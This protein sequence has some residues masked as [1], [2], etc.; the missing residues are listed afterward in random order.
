V[1]DYRQR[2][3]R[4]PA[5]ARVA[6]LCAELAT[7]LA[8]LAAT[9]PSEAAPVE[10]LLTVAEA[11]ELLRISRT[12]AYQVIRTGELASVRIRGRR[13]IPTSAVGALVTARVS[14]GGSF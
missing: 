11:A 9:R 7:A 4:S 10:R 3:D 6:Q 2:A 12:T 8:E 1:T 13:L 5:E 14:E